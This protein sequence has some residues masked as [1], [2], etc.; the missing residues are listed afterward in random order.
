MTKLEKF[1]IG[2]LN[3][4]FN[5]MK[6]FIMKEYP[7]YLFHMKDGKCILQHNIKD[8]SIYVNYRTI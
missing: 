8:R 4:S 7:D 6:P 2:W 3:D 5:N 1:C